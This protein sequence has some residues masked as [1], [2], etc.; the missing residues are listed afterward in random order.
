MKAEDYEIATADMAMLIDQW[1]PNER[2]RAITKRKLCDGITFAKLAEE[3]DMS[4]RQ[5]KRIVYKCQD[6][7]FRH[8]ELRNK[9][10]HKCVTGC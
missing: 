7:V 4:D 1:I 6:R 8:V 5:I 9:D 3:F 2:N 10:G